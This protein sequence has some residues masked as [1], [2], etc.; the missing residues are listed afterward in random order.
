MP[1][2]VTL[3]EFLDQA[4]TQVSD[5]GIF[6]GG[7]VMVSLDRLLDRLIEYA[8]AVD[9]YH[10]GTPSP[11]SHTFLLAEPYHGPTTEIVECTVRTKDNKIIWDQDHVNPLKIL[12]H[13]DVNSGICHGTVGDYDDH[14]VR[15][16]GIKWIPGL[17]PTQRHSLAQEATDPKWKP[18]HYDFPGLL[19]ELI[20]LATQSMIKPAPGQDLL[21]CSAFVQR[22]YSNVLGNAGD[23]KPGIRD[24]D[25]SP[26]DLWY[27]DLGTRIGP[28]QTS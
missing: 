2:P 12:F 18:Y 15:R 4:V 11:W 23:F 6:E 22:V 25:A 9:E 24:E 1:Q 13:E 14:R 7:I 8:L 20:R 27:P 19:R 10:P 28:A 26:D 5:P 3:S 21:F 16:W 17:T